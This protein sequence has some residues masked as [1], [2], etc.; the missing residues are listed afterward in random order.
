VEN[1]VYPPEC[2]W[3]EVPIS[4]KANFCDRCLRLLVSDYYR[5][6]RCA[7]PLPAVVPNQNCFRCRDSGWRFDRVITLGPY[8]EVLRQ[9]VIL[10]KKPYQESLRRA[11]GQLMAIAA[12][13]LEFPPDIA[14]LLIPVPNHWTHALRG[15]ADT[16]GSLAR[17]ISR[18]TGWQLNAS[19]IRRT[20]K[21]A[22]QG[23][24]SWSDRR[25]NVRGAFEISHSGAV[26]ARHVILVD[27][28]L[29]SG[30]TA[31]ELASRLKRAG[32]NS[33]HVL[34]AARGTGARESPGADNTLPPP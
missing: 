16:A 30:A 21:T 25:Q 33:V 12:Q 4:D 26:T 24:L 9:A 32:A 19:A 29:T 28:V 20:R 10:I 23:M 7:T 18:Q 8:R 14:P 5:C 22:K 6:Q 27:D 3:C 34:V 15:A 2:L 31:A 17:T 1:L 13:S 11:L